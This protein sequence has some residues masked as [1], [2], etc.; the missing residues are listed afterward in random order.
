MHFFY[1]IC[2]CNYC[3]LVLSVSHQR[4]RLP[5]QWWRIAWLGNPFYQLRQ[6]C[7]DDVLICNYLSRSGAGGLVSIYRL[8]LNRLLLVSFCTIESK[9]LINPGHVTMMFVRKVWSPGFWKFR[10][11]D[12]QVCLS[13]EEHKIKWIKV[14]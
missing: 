9:W 12:C 4:S 8:A 11:Y 5:P 3:R 2:K 13:F 6:G 10:S 14:K 1:A 7:V